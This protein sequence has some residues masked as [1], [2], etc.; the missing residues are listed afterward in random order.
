MQLVYLKK[1]RKQDLDKSMSICSQSVESFWG[2]SLSD[3]QSRTKINVCHRDDPDNCLEDITIHKANNGNKDWRIT[4]KSF[5]DLYMRS[6]PVEDDIFIVT[7]TSDKFICGVVKSTD[8]EYSFLSSFFKD[9]DN[10]ALVSFD[11]MLDESVNNDASHA[12]YVNLLKE[13]KNLILTGAPGT[14][15]TYLAKQIAASIISG[16]TKE[17]NTLTDEEKTQVGF[18]QFHPSYDYTDFVEGL[19]PNSDSSFSRQDGVFK[20]FC[21]RAI[22]EKFA[23]SANISYTQSSLTSTS[24][25]QDIIDSIKDDIRL[26]I[27]LS[28]SPTGKLRINANNRIEYQTEKTLK[29]ILE[30]NLEL[31]FNH[32]VQIGK[33]NL[34]DITKVELEKLLEDLTTKA[35]E[36][37]T[38]TIDY[39]H[40]KWTLAELLKRKYEIDEGTFLK[41]TV[42]ESIS[43]DRQN[44][45]YIFIIDEINRGELSK[46]FGELFYSIEPSYRGEEGR[47]TTQYNRLVEDGDIFKEGFYIPQ[48]VYIIGTMNDVDRGV[49]A[50]DFAIRRRFAWREVTAAESAERMGIT[51]LTLAKME[52][53]NNALIKHG[54]TEAHCIGGAYFLKLNG[55]NNYDLLWANH[56]KGIVT[57]YFRGEPDASTKIKEIEAIFKQTQLPHLDPEDNKSVDTSEA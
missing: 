37:I 44:K 39:T 12:E 2:V 34:D 26:G 55:S 10:Y 11:N 8:P 48:N 15:K 40:Y 49:E 21:K 16:G 9:K 28:Y 13:H 24:T 14:G 53:M 54:L 42:S 32:F 29:T 47:V 31:L 57:E 17:W 46:I 1:L 52:A 3:H 7:K 30:S 22:N 25:F 18:V 33:F 23:A 4:G 27:L 36:R 50:M 5:K 19:R 38:R 51:G 45:E 43:E 35:G 41:P 20:A 6:K 56:L